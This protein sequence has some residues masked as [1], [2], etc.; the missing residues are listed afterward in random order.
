MVLGIP[1]V[2]IA[3]SLLTGR[4]ASGKGKVSR[5]VQDEKT[6]GFVTTTNGVSRYWSAGYSVGLR[7]LESVMK[8]YASIC[9]SAMSESHRAA[10]ELLLGQ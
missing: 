7:D 10:R 3:K 6:V 1:S 9:L 2:G 4:V 8:R 5:I